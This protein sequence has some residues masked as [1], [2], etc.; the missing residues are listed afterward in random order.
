MNKQRI[1]NEEYRERFLTNEYIK[2][3]RFDSKI[4]DN[5]LSDEELDI[6][7]QASKSEHIRYVHD[8]SAPQHVSTV[9]HYN[10]FGDFYNNPAWSHLVEIMQPKLQA[11]FGDDIMASHI[12]VL[13]SKFPYGI[14]NDAEQASLEI[15]PDPAWTIIIP[16]EDYNSK[17]YVFNERS[18]YKNP[19]EMAEKLGIEP[20]DVPAVDQDTWEKDFKPFT[21]F[22]VLEY[23]TVETTFKWKKGS[24][25]AADRFKYHCSD[26]Y[27]NH[28]LDGKRAIIIWTSRRS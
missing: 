5:F 11:H 3:K 15:A 1:S 7:D 14:H 10:I 20:Y 13:D 16:L 22:N 28:G 27:F 8:N 24:C 9:A 4:I 25:F 2:D 26:N 18:P 23:L 17:T 21:G 19:I 6:F 12:H